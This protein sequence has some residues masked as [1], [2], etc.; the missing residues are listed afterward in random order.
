VDRGDA[1][2]ASLF[3]QELLAIVVSEGSFFFSNRGSH[4]WDL[5]GGRSLERR[6]E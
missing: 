1:H 2:V 4:C 5:M 3:P 6:E